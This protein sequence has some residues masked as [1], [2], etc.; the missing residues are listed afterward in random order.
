LKTLSIVIVAW[1]S[2]ED[3]A[4]CVAS[5]ARERPN[6]RSAVEL[7]VVD[8]ASAAFPEAAIHRAWPDARIERLAANTGFGPASNRGAAIAS[9]D[10]LLF[11]NPDTRAAGPYYEP[12]AGAF[13]RYPAAVAAA[14]RLEASGP[15]GGEPQAEF[16]LRRLPTL[17]SAFRELALVDRGW[18]RNPWRARD[19][20][21]D[22]DRSMPFLVEQPAAAA[23]AV[24][25]SAFEAVGGFDESFVPAWWE[26]VDLCE[27]L[28]REGSLTYLPEP[29]FRHSGGRA[30]RT[31]G[32]DVFLPIYHRNAIRY[33]RKHG[34]SLPTAAYRAMVCGGMLLRMALLPVRRRD[35]R[36]KRQSWRAYRGALGVALRGS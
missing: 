24:R 26:D 7:V 11:L 32:Y 25:R 13:D 31:L 21:L 6:D 8:N 14:P 28:S 9:G 15:E 1:N 2:S 5:L 27:R 18:P 23:L 12:L 4:E 34:G 10:V 17:A 20:Y 3:L 30:M 36:P 22:R 29:S 35:P 16:Q 19:R 33:W